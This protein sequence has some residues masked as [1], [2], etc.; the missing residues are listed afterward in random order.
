MHAAPRARD[1]SAP[2]RCDRDRGTG[3]G[4]SPAFHGPDRSLVDDAGPSPRPEGPSEETCRKPLRPGCRCGDRGCGRPGRRRLLRGRLEPGDDPVDRVPPGVRGSRAGDGVPRRG[5]RSARRHRRGDLERGQE[6]GDHAVRGTSSEEH[7][8]PVRIRQAWLPAESVRRGAGRRYL[9]TGG[10]EACSRASAQAGGG[11]G[12]ASE[13]GG[14]QLAADLLGADVTEE[15]GRKLL[16]AAV[17]RGEHDL[18]SVR[19]VRRELIERIELETTA[20]PLRMA[21]RDR[22]PDGFLKY[23]FELRDGARVE[24]VRIPIPC[25]APGADV[26]AYAGKE[27]KYVVCVSSQAG[28]ALAC[29]FCATGALGF[30]RNLSADEIVGQVLAVREEA[31][32]PVRGIVFMGMGEPFLNYDAV[33]K[34]ARILS[35]PSGGSIDGRAITIS[36]AGVVPAIRRY[37]REGH[38][39]RL[40]VS[41]THAVPDKRAALMPI[42]RVHASADLV[43]AIHDHARARRQRVLVEYVLLGDVN[44]SPADARALA[45][46]FDATLVKIDLIDVNGS[47]GGFHRASREARSAFLDVL[48]SARIPFAIR[49]SGGQDVAAGCGQLAGGKSGLVRLSSRA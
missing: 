18:R 37:T 15:I 36:T 11:R 24:A 31:D 16:A 45:E 47:T 27:K 29:A 42:E 23:L 2:G 46:L 49:Y 44:D 48:G 10:G 19:G 21:A 35:H 41:L 30:E 17:Q 1:G 22:A 12:A 25:E 6:D 28:C 5:L 26:S 38:K 40:A 3:E 39:F 4:S 32:R 14:E 34:A 20:E 43:A 7:Q 9:A 8:G 13:E 33:V